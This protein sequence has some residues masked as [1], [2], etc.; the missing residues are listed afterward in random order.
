MWGNGKPGTWGWGVV[1][2]KEGELGKG[3]RFIKSV[4]VGSVAEV[5]TSFWKRNVN[6]RSCILLLCNLKA[7][8][9]QFR[10]P[11]YLV[12]ILALSK[13]DSLVHLVRRR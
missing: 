6:F 2:L 12:N 5:F 8:S 9:L 13:V 11:H 4:L 3:F 1:D 7:N 10:S